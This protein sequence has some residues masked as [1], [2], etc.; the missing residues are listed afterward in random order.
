[1]LRPLASLS[2]KPVFNQDRYGAVQLEG[3]RITSFTEKK[4]LASGLINAGVSILTPE[5]FEGKIL[6]DV[7][8]YEKDLF[9]KKR[10]LTF[11]MALCK[12][13]IL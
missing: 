5:I 3:D 9:E 4:F 12:M 8:S 13:N 6:G 2:L 1:M 7:F 11:Y 10:P